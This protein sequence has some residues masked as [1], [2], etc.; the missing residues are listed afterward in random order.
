[1][2]HRW[3]LLFGLWILVPSVSPAQPVFHRPAGAADL[4]EVAAGYQAL[5]TCSAHFFAG[6]P[7]QDILEVELVDLAPLD[8][9]PPEIDERRRLVRSTD[10]RGQTMVAAFREDVGC[11]LLPPH[12]TEADVGHLPYIERAPPPD[13]EGLPFPTGDRARPRPNR[14][15][16]RLL[17]EA[18]D[19]ATFG[20]GTVTV[21]V[22]I[23]REGQIAAERYRE[24][25]GIHTGYRT[26]STAKSISAALIGIAV[27]KGLLSVDEPAPI[28]EWSHFQ[29]PRQ[30]ITLANLLHMSS[31]LMS[32]GSDTNAIYFGGQDV[33]SAAT[34]TPL[35]AEP[36]T[37]WKYA[38]NDTLLALRALRAVLGD[39]LTYMRFPYD[40]LFSKIGMHHTRMEMD[41]RGNFVGSSQVYTTARDLARFGLLHLQQGVW[42][43][44]RVLPEG[45]TEFVAAPAPARSAEPETRG[46]GAQFWLLDTFEGV[47]PGTYTTAGN[48][49]QYVTIVPEKDL[50]IVRTGVDP[51]GRRWIPEAFVKEVVKFFRP[52][53]NAG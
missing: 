29:D 23:V 42:Q 12:W 8:L 13:V 18:F 25:F 43:G 14:A 40:E 7:V 4:E 53:P 22:V 15:Q 35:V 39:D 45:W 34:T 46:Y 3:P 30:R 38:N 17:E 31:G 20:D 24:G 28:P 1:M 37:R 44:E 19:G 21:G 5:F 27:D 2:R 48:K 6:R 26:W 51:N 33:I 11:T 49:G 47:P 52:G 32:Q 36:N 9:P 16:R 41:H 10:H 50:V